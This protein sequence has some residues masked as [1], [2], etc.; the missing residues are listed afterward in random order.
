MA[1]SSR[2]LSKSSSVSIFMNGT[3]TVPMVSPIL[4]VRLPPISTLTPRSVPGLSALV[5]TLMQCMQRTQLLLSTSS[6]SSSF[7]ES[8]L[9]GQRAM[10]LSIVYLRPWLST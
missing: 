3:I 10:T 6:V 7:S 1:A 8:A 4:S 2:I 5:M 9:V